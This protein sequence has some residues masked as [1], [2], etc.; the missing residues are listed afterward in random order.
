MSKLNTKSRVSNTSDMVDRQ[1]SS[2][3]IKWS[4]NNLKLNFLGESMEELVL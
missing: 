2:T 4:E 3:E 1:L